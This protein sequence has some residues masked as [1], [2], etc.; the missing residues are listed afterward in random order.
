MRF[1]GA[2]LLLL[3]LKTGAAPLCR[4]NGGLDP[5]AKAGISETL[6]GFFLRAARETL[7]AGVPVP[8]DCDPEA[9]IGWSA[10]PLAKCGLE[11]LALP[12]FDARMTTELRGRIEKESGFA[13]KA[14]GPLFTRAFAELARMEDAD[15]DA[16]PRT[17]GNF[18]AAILAVVGAE[19][20]PSSGGA[21]EDEP[22]QLRLVP[23]LQPQRHVR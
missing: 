6:G 14:A 8:L 18:A 22:L 1:L 20:C 16:R 9:A 5:G 2:L 11:K 4:L 3:S 7:G 19:N 23:A 10:Q 17:L 13:A 12:E 15:G 21:P